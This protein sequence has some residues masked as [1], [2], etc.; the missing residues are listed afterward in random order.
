MHW[1]PRG[2]PFPP[3]F[4]WQRVED[5]SLPL[6]YSRQTTLALRCFNQ[7]ALKTN[8]NEN[9]QLIWIGWKIKWV[10]K[11]LLHFQKYCKL[12]EYIPWKLNRYACTK[13]CLMYTGAQIQQGLRYSM[14]SLLPILYL[15]SQCGFFHYQEEVGAANPRLSPNGLAQLAGKIDFQH[16]TLLSIKSQQTVGLFNLE[17]T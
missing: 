9:M 2:I 14:W 4:S 5:W 17:L 13:K 11:K 7:F 6:S 3:L 8:S 10:S 15:D 16:P 12:N 1:S